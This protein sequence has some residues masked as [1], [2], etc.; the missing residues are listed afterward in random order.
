[1]RCEFRDKADGERCYAVAARLAR[2]FASSVATGARAHTVSIDVRQQ[3]RHLPIYSLCLFTKYQ[4]A[5]WDFVDIAGGAHL[6]WIER[7]ETDVREAHMAA[8]E[9]SGQTPL[10]QEPEIDRSSIEAA[11][12]EHVVPYLTD[13]I[14]T[15]LADG[16]LRFV[17]D[18]EALLGEVHGMARTTHVRTAIKTLYKQGIIDSDGTGDFFMTAIALVE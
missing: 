15:V 13:R 14:P 7:C 3:P 4:Q 2:S 12:T 17:D 1:M 6:D 8:I 10:F 18:P 16:P 9:M 11:L 5:V